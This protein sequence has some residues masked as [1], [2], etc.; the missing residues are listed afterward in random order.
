MTR[1]AS[2]EQG[3]YYP[4]AIARLADA[5]VLG[6]GTTSIGDYYRVAV[7]ELGQEAQQA[8]VM[9]NNHDLLVRHLEGRQE[10]ISGVSLDEETV[11]MLQYQRTYQAAARM[12]TTVDEMLEKGNRVIVKDLFNVSPH[13]TGAGF[14]A[15]TSWII[16]VTFSL[17]PMFQPDGFFQF[18]QGGK[19]SGVGK[20]FLLIQVFA[21]LMDAGLTKTPNDF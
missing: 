8:N 10:E 7:A 19:N 17:G 12:M 13:G 9:A 2:L 11:Y 20:F 1:L 6:G 14:F 18:L 15:G 4:S 21:N 16:D 3:G 5:A